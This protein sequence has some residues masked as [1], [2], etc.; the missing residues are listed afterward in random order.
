MASN[1]LEIELSVLQ[2]KIVFYEKVLKSIPALICINSI[3]VPHNPRSMI[4]V[5]SNDFTLRFVGYTQ[6]E[7]DSLGFDFFERVIH[8]ADLEI[9]DTMLINQPVDPENLTFTVML[10]L[11]PRGDDNY[12]WMYGNSIVLD[13][14]DNGHPKTSLTV[15][16]EI[17]DS[18]HTEN[19]L[20]YALQRINRLKN[21][22]K[23]RSL[24]T[25][26]KEVLKHIV[27]GYTDKEISEKLCI[28]I[29]TAKT[30]RNRV[31]RKLGFRNS[32]SLAAFAAGCGLV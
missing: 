11:R 26:E 32:A 19:Q 25:R 7:I 16:V 15:I 22:I 4:N 23:C 30:H 17:T 5:W 20:V 31:I 24:T 28:S 6:E 8:P 18:M 3:A 2:Q 29:A 1:A 21:E 14:Y 12:R 27:T 13:R 10:R 9:I